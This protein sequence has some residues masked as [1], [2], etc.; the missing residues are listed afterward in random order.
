MSEVFDQILNN[1]Y[2]SKVYSTDYVAPHNIKKR[3]KQIYEVVANTIYPTKQDDIEFLRQVWPSIEK[4]VLSWKMSCTREFNLFYNLIDNKISLESFCFEVRDETFL[5][6]LRRSIYKRC[7]ELTDPKLKSAKPFDIDTFYFN[8]IKLDLGLYTDQ[9]EIDEPEDYI[10]E[11]IRY[12][13]KLGYTVDDGFVIVKDQHLYLASK[14]KIPLTPQLFN[15]CVLPWDFEE[16]DVG[17]LKGLG[18]SNKT[19]LRTLRKVGYIS[20]EKK[21]YEFNRSRLLHLYRRYSLSDIYIDWDMMRK[22]KF[23]KYSTLQ[24]IL[25][26]TFGEELDVIQGL[27]YADLIRRLERIC[28]VT[29]KFHE[30]SLNIVDTVNGM[31]NGVRKAGYSY[32]F[33]TQAEGSDGAIWYPDLE[34]K[35]SLIYDN[36][37][38]MKIHIVVGYEVY[39]WA[40]RRRDELSI[41]YFIFLAQQTGVW[42]EILEG[43]EN[44][45]SSLI[46]SKI[47]ELIR[48]I[49]S[50]NK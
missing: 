4:T 17:L 39:L 20:S 33:S 49:E 50:L 16:E 25:T 22:Y 32:L 2:A 15:S 6:K 21:D 10:Q 42:D 24:E 26:T 5:W 36:I 43:G 3:Y 7:V 40:K 29:G 30:N 48:N 46:C 44:I 11:Y 27:T 35:M 37:P 18:W 12:Y 1:R 41:G 19:L 47:D 14:D 8:T 38:I 13:S 28:N 31:I 9:I 45:T 34:G 23:Y